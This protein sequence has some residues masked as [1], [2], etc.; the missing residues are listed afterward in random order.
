VSAPVKI[1]VLDNG[2]FGVK[3]KDSDIPAYP[4]KFTYTIVV[5]GLY[6]DVNRAKPGIQTYLDK[7][8]GV[9]TNIPWLDQEGQQKY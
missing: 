1:K 3:S 6:T 5:S 7:F 2:E 9:V 8:Q 4:E